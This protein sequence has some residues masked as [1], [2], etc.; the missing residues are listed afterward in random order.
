M[1]RVIADY[2]Y[3]D[4]SDPIRVRVDP[5]GNIQYINRENVLTLRLAM[6]F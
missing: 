6:D 1:L 5:N 2:T 4:L 3:T